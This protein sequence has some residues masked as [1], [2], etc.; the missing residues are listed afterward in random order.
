[1][2]K[3]AV[4]NT[5][6]GEYYN[7]VKQG[8]GIFRWASGNVYVGHYKNDERD[9]KGEMTWTDGSKYVGDW[10]N[11]IQNGYGK[12]VFPNG[13]VK[14][15]Y[16]DNNIYKG[17]KKPDEGVVEDKEVRLNN[18]IDTIEQESLW[19]RY[20]QTR[21]P[22]KINKNLSDAMN[23]GNGWYQDSLPGINSTAGA[24]ENDAYNNQIMNTT[25]PNHLYNRKQNTVSHTQISFNRGRGKQSSNSLRQK[26]GSTKR[27]RISTANSSSLVQKRRNL[28]TTSTDIKRRRP[29][30][31]KY[32][33]KMTK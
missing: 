32:R 27:P 22:K 15:G 14:E 17:K 8:E 1:M 12:M 3:G 30:I 26:F 7:D 24:Y 10:K 4:S 28:N 20:G 19:E 6:E 21:K 16:F 25:D 2:K 9:G 5:Y 29:N 33:P 11:G 18:K 31:P 13:T 23:S